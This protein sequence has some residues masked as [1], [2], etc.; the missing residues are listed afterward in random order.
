MV[1]FNVVLLDFENSDIEAVSF[2]GV[3][4]RI[5]KFGCCPAE[6]LSFLQHTLQTRIQN[7]HLKCS[8][9]I[10]S[11]NLTFIAIKSS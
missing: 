8:S 10:F 2:E 6:M 5:V 3:G 9:N 4:T 7:S 1:D 11:T